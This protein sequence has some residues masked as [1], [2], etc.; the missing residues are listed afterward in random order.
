VRGLSHLREHPRD[1]TIVPLVTLVTIVLA[2]PVKLF[3]F[4][5]MNRQAW[6]TRR[7]DVVVAAGQDHASLDGCA[8]LS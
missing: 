7:D 6:L 3:A 5:T 8:V 2:V 1:L 4:V